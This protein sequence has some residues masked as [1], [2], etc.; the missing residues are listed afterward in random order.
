VAIGYRAIQNGFETHFT[1]DAAPPLADLIKTCGS[2]VL[3]W[4]LG[5]GRRS[6]F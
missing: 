2:V 4:V 6:P 3:G 5:F 1:T